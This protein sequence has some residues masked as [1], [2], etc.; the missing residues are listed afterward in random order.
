[1]ADALKVVPKADHIETGVRNVEGI[2]EGL[3]NVLADTYRLVF[4][5]HAYHWNVTGPLF[6]SMHKMTEAQYE[7]M[8][9]AA[10]TLA[11]RIRALGQIAPMRLDD[12]IE[13]S[14]VKDPD[15][16]PNAGQMIDD[17]VADHELLAHRFRALSI[18]SDE[19]FDPMTDDLAADRAGF[20]E[21]CAW[22]LRAL[23]SE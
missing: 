18:L 12:L 13:R 15:A 3:A 23:R 5:T 17:L 14:R 10:D 8:F 7:D 11:E 6:Y 4:K 9:K 1:M 22:M 19:G 20:H 2:A 16:T 21:E